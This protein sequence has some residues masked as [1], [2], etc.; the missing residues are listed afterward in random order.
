MRKQGKL[1]TKPKSYYKLS[2]EIMELLRPTETEEEVNAY[3]E[4][5]EYCIGLNIC[6]E[7][8]QGVI[9]TDDNREEH[10]KEYGISG[11]CKACQIK[12]FGE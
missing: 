6:S 9:I 4:H 5:I 12:V 3:F 7:C 2:P 11:L 1:D 8:G 10:I